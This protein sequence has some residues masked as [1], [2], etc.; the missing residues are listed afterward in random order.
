MKE[1]K[2]PRKHLDFNYAR[3]YRKIKRLVRADVRP[4]EM[5]DEA[6]KKLYEMLLEAQGNG[7]SVQA[8]LPQGFDVFYSEFVAELPAFTHEE[9][10]QRRSVTHFL[11]CS[12][13]AFLAVLVLFSTTLVNDY[14]IAP[15]SNYFAYAKNGF[16]HIVDSDAYF[17]TAYALSETIP[18]EIDFDD[19]KSAEGKCIFDG[20]Y[21]KIVIE[22]ISVDGENM[23]D[24]RIFFR[25]YPVESFEFTQMIT[26][27]AL[28]KKAFTPAAII[29]S[30][31]RKDYECRITGSESPTLWYGCLV[32]ED[33]VGKYGDIPLEDIHGVYEFALRELTLNTWE[34][35]PVIR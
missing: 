25:S 23:Q 30:Y 5:R 21:G 12:C 34:I 13:I 11:Y 29:Y 26:G 8:L 18:F 1:K 14:I 6:M 2:K 17:L 10:L 20:E 7:V 28:S 22:K 19:I 33:F 35:K 31:N 9:K 32:G 16:S 27:V 24:V 15:V 3:L 4:H